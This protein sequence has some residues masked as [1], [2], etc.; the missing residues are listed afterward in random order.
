M[1]ISCSFLR[2]LL[3]YQIYVSLQ[4]G[5]WEDSP[6]FFIGVSLRIPHFDR[7]VSFQ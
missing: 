7:R 4:V 6:T 5:H 2:R 1:V 3:S